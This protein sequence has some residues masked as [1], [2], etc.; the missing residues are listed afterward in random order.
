MA[1]AQVIHIKCDRC[2]REELQPMGPSK[3]APDFEAKYKGS[4]ILF[5]DLCD[6]C[7]E[8]VTKLWIELK[9]WDKQI[10]STMWKGPRVEDNKAPP[11]NPSPDNSPPKPHSLA[12]VNKR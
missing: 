5:A 4:T 10:I 11:M 12:A 6:R 2:K 1:R 9:E 8:A 3:E 7:R